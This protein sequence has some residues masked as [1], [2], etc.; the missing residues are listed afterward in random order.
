MRP[1]G[2]FIG[3]ALI[4]TTLSPSIALGQQAACP[5]LGPKAVI[6]AAGG[7]AAG[8]AIG[9]AVGG[10]NRGLSTALGGFGGALLG[11]AVGSALDQRDCQQAQLDLK[12]LFNAL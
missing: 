9:S 7:A 2:A 11:G 3:L 5:A 10:R 1:T 6:G 4:A 8:A 12:L